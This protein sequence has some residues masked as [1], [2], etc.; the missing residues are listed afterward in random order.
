MVIYVQ[1]SACRNQ[2]KSIKSAC[3]MASVME[4]VT[5]R[6]SCIRLARSFFSGI[7]KPDDLHDFWQQVS[8]SD[9]QPRFD[10]DIDD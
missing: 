9:F 7:T 8:S 6:G 1:G 4:G 3:E 10:A 5:R 2:I